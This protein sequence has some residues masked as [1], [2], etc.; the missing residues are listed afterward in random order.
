MA[1][2]KDTGPPDVIE[3]RTLRSQSKP[4]K[5]AS[6]AL[7]P[8]PCRASAKKRA[9]LAVDDIHVSHD[10]DES[11][12]PPKLRPKPKPKGKGKKCARCKAPAGNVDADEHDAA[13][14]DVPADVSNNRKQPPRKSTVQT[15][16]STVEEVNSDD[17]E[18]VAL[19]RSKRTRCDLVTDMVPPLVRPPSEGM[20]EHAD[21][22]VPI[23]SVNAGV[24]M[25][26]ILSDDNEEDAPSDDE[27]G[28]EFDVI[29]HEDVAA[30]TDVMGID[31][32]TDG[33]VRQVLDREGNNVGQ[34]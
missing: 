20:E 6:E 18:D 17:L 22:D 29:M 30:V 4:D 27:L 11:Q 2:R 7:P 19:P 26:A 5:V 16:H 33:D 13:D 12:V 9:S 21:S 23:G 28:V 31:T 34:E 10:E 25:P 32:S 1:R 15:T 3:P 8:L 24:D 14:E